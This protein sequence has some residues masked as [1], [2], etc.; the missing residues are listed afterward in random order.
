M[1]GFDINNNIIIPNINKTV[2]FIFWNFLFLLNNKSTM[3]ITMDPTNVYNINFLVINSF[4]FLF[5]N[6]NLRIKIIIKS[7]IKKISKVLIR[8]LNKG[9][10]I[11]SSS[12]LRTLM[13]IVP[14]NHKGNNTSTLNNNGI[15][16]TID[17]DWI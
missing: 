9:D 11:N 4:N 2:F 13:T 8:N 17:A 10:P 5:G 12:L 6:N 1:N 15:L 14:N 7:K 16:S 3:F